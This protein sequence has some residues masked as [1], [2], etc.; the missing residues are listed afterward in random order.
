MVVVWATWAEELIWVS[1][2]SKFIVVCLLWHLFKLTKTEE[3][4]SSYNFKIHFF[5][6]K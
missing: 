6:P 1:A 3:R 2:N 5:V 4:V